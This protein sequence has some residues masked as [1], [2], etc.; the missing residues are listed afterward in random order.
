MEEEIDL[1]DYLR[2]IK[3]RK[4][5]I[6]IIFIIMVGLGIVISL[7]MPHIYESTVLLKIGLLNKVPLE[8]VISI[9]TILQ[10]KDTLSE[11]AQLLGITDQQKILGLT[12]YFDI[13]AIKNT[14]LFEIKGRGK[15]PA[16]SVK[17]T[18]SVKN[19]LLTH[20]QEIFTKGREGLELD[21]RQIEQKIK[22]NQIYID[23]SD[24]R[25]VSLQLDQSELKQKIS[26]LE[27]T[28][29][30]AQSRIT[31]AYIDSLNYIKEQV[32]NEQ[33][34]S[35]SLKTQ[36]LNLEKSLQNRQFDATY[37]TIMT[38]VINQPYLPQQ[39]IS[40]KRAQNVLIA[41]VLGLFIAIL[42]A[43]IAEYFS[44]NQQIQADKRNENKEITE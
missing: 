39:R 7:L 28:Q 26:Q 32:I 29:S 35:K 27:N 6:I 33:N 40:P 13:D 11:I 9:K 14:D 36:T 42:W 8:N 12:K 15:T 25:L 31:A 30:E 21:V 5:G 37:N 44:Q 43:F 18:N 23:E 3:Q 10:Q 2:V 24:A 1:R 17:I 20:Q 22:E 19:V 16:E 41:A 38:Q 4:K 34:N